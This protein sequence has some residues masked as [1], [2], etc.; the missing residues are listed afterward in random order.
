MISRKEQLKTI[1]KY[2]L[3]DFVIIGGG[4]SGLGTA[5]DAAS[6]GYQTI[7]FESVD[8][9]KGT[10]S[11][12]TKLIHGGIRYLAQGKY[13][14]VKQALEERGFL[15][16]N[17]KHLFKKQKFIIPQYNWWLGLYYMIG[18]SIYN[19]LAGNLAIGKTKKLNRNNTIKK[20]PTLIRKNLS[21]GIVYHDGV[22]DDARL[23]VNLA[24]TAIEFG[25]T[26]INHIKVIDLL[27][28]ESGKLFGVIAK[29]KETGVNYKIR[30]KVVLNATGVFA[31]K[32]MKL[33][34]RNNYGLKIV[35]SQGV[36]L[37]LDSKFLE[38]NDALMIP[39]TSDGRVIFAIPWHK[40]LLVGTTDTPIKKPIY[41]P[42]A[43]EEEIEFILSTA[44]SYL[45][46]KP[47]REDVLSVFAGLRP[48]VAFR[49]D[50]K[51]T[52]EI[53]RGHKIIESESGLISIIGGKW[54]TYRHM[55]EE[56]VNMA[57]KAHGLDFK[58]CKTKELSIHGNI[59][60]E[61]QIN[62]HLYVYG[63]D[64]PK[65]LDVINENTLFKEKIH[66]NY[67][68]KIGEVVWCIRHEMARTLEDILARRI[69][70]LFLDAR[71]AIESVP[72]VAKIMAD[73]LGKDSYWIQQQEKEFKNLAKN[74]VLSTSKLRKND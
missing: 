15:A 52:K 5:L 29:D 55:S 4:A 25:A 14:L 8:F 42:K 2:P 39:K 70:L 41:E 17:A 46:K 54:T 63:S 51:H 61:P 11:R 12:S 19:L 62:S 21:G 20:L 47:K 68:Y 64:I 67:E 26:V 6:R 38:S 32:I 18:L 33:D 72:K 35:P 56:L 48:L 3:W 65:V 69:R 66:P 16:K 28:D 23:A 60:A 74:Y 7:L 53:S 10:S 36:H 58:P 9:G 27:K 37:V 24:Q 43:L 22:F 1:K 45:S 73:E 49:G 57:I 13:R 40:K 30:S 71:A 44:D 34:G 50:K 59:N 31:N